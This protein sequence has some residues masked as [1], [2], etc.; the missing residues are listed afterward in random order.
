MGFY[1]RKV[2]DNMTKANKQK[3]KKKKSKINLHIIL[4]ALMAVVFLT[5][6]FKLA[7]WDKRVR[8]NTA[9]ENDTTLSFETEALD[10]IVPLD[11]SNGK[12]KE[13]DTDLRILF[14][15]NGSLADDKTSNEN[16]ANVVQAKTGA[17]VYNCAIPDTYMSM[18]NS[19]YKNTFIYDAFSFY[20][21]CTLFTVNNK[22]TISWAERDLGGLPEDVAAPL[23]LLQSIDYNELDILCVYYDGSDYL[24]QRGAYDEEADT[25]P[26]QF[27]G[28]LNA[29]L[30]LV[31]EYLPH[32]RIIVMS[33]TYVYV[34]DESGKYS[35][36]FLTNILEE[37]LST[38]V[39]LQAQ[40][41]INRQVS[42]VDNLYGSVY[43]EVADDYLKDN[44]LLNA[45][46]HALLADR[47][48]YALNRF[49]EYDF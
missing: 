3:R 23:T 5:I 45:K 4:L 24:D 35:S 27:C 36:S 16:L 21:L 44:I 13:K 19:T 25:D 49:H 43:E 2:L 41:C 31:K 15:G 9:R 34:I 26:T 47:F 46:G 18:K 20:N 8:Q 33:P 40:N 39:G 6:I 32:V 7:F 22:E 37:P 48:L 12:N 10:T 17:T 42:F 11:S 29:G 38:Y 28:A 14:L 30:D 1:E